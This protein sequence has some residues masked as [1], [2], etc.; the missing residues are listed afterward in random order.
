[1]STLTV[2]GAKGVPYN[3][4]HYYHLAAKRMFD[5]HVNFVDFGETKPPSDYYIV[6]DAGFTPPLD[7]PGERTVFIAIDSHL[8]DFRQNWYEQTASSCKVTF[9]VT[10]G[11]FDRPQWEG[12]SFY[13]QL[14]YPL[15]YLW[16]EDSPKS[17]DVCFVGGRQNDGLR[18]QILKK[19]RENFNVCFLDNGASPVVCNELLRYVINGSKV[20][21]DISPMESNYLGQRFFDNVGCKSNCVALYREELASLSAFNYW[22]APYLFWGVEDVCEVIHKAISYPLKPSDWGD[23]SGH[24]YDSRLKNTILPQLLA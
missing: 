13:M 19:V 17:F 23:I 2:I 7:V 3:Q 16:W 14:A 20:S 4:C 18:G 5:G 24:S 15:D 1:M 9:Y 12:K 6:V 11:L 10:K 22:D 8:L 21:L